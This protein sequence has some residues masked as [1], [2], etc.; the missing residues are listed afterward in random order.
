[1]PLEQGDVPLGQ[2]GAPQRDGG[3]RLQQRD[4]PRQRGD[5][6][7]FELGWRLKEPGTPSRLGGT[8]SPAPGLCGSPARA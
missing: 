2:S 8:R 5:K 1:M 3:A 6:R 7:R 4:R